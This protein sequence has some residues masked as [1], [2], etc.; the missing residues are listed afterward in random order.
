MHLIRN[1]DC[2]GREFHFLIHHKQLYQSVI[3]GILSII[4]TMFLFSVLI[5]LVKFSGSEHLL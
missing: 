2:F 3:G 4:V 5:S 1:V